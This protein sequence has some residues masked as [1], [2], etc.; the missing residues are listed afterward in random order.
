MSNQKSFSQILRYLLL[1]LVFLV[2]HAV[3]GQKTVLSGV[4]QGQSL[5]IQNPYLVSEHKYCIDT[6]I[7]NKQD[8]YINPQL[9]AVKLDFGKEMLFAPVM[10]MI[11]HKENCKPKFINP[12]AI[13]YHSSFKF[14]SLVV[15]DSL[16]RWHTKGEKLEGLYSIEKLNGTY[17]QV[18]NTIKPKGQFEG[19]DYIYFPEFD[20]GG[21]RFRIKYSLPD[22]RYIYSGEV[23]MFYFA[24]P[25]TFSPKSVID[26]MVLSQYADYQIM[27]LKGNVIVS[28]S[29]KVI[30]LRKL[31]RGDYFIYLEGDTES[32]A[33]TFPFN[34]K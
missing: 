17:W 2:Q 21:N 8:I 25:I 30:P 13:L 7:V 24:K 19:A 16:I 33:V 10:V 28:G 31:K 4:Y 9:S 34:K 18:M 29:G 11:K 27:D 32:S 20:K 26:E 23:E 5:Y 22:N 14:D 3:N 6:I 12:E 1:I 15:N